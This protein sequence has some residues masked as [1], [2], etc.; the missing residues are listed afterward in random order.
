MQNPSFP[1]AAIRGVTAPI[2]CNIEGSGY[3]AASALTISSIRARIALA[4]PV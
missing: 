4:L 2:L 1:D 3:R